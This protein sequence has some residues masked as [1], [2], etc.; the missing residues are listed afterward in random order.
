MT[1]SKV[2]SS[3]IWEEICMDFDI[4]TAVLSDGAEIA[5]LNRIAM[6]YDH[7]VEE[8]VRNLRRILSKESDRVFVAAMGSAIVGYI[9]AC[10]YELLYNAPMKNIMGIAVDPA[11]RRMGIG[12]ALMSA[13]EDWAEE[14]GACGIRLVSGAERVDA[15]EFYRR[16]GFSGEKKQVNFKKYFGQP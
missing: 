11:F 1:F 2:W 7:P 12:K 15:H 14:T 16:L 13:V 3:A 5:R 9:H 6:G 4:R 8:T 10:D